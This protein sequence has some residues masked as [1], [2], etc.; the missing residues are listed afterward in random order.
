MKDVIVRIKDKK[1][2]KFFKE[3]INEFDFLEVISET[4]AKPKT[5]MQKRLLEGF[6][7]IGMHE[8]GK[9]QLKSGREILNDL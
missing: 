1:K 6:K 3:L 5:H 7:A 4:S 8:E 2:E 9:I